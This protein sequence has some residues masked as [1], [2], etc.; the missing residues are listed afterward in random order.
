MSTQIQIV[1]PARLASTRL[2]EKLLRDAEGK[3]IL[4]R[5]FEAASRSTVADGVIVAVDDQRLADEVESFGGKWMMTSR[6]CASGTDRIAEVA[7][8]MKEVDIFVNVQGDE[9]EIEPVV[10]DRVATALIDA[11]DAD[12][13]TVGTPIRDQKILD[14]P[15]CVK[16][17]MAHQP[18]ALAASPE[19]ASPTR[20][21]QGRAEQGR[22]VYFSRAVV[23]H[24]RDGIDQ[25]TLASEPPIY[26]HHIGLYA[27]RRDFLAW[28][29][30]QPP[31]RLE[32]TERLEQ[33]RAIEAGKKIVVSR[34]ESATPGI[35]TE[36]DL[37]AFI[38]RL[39]SER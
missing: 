22:A 2:P 33:L 17:V 28:F 12:M 15:S 25:S 34:V 21:G 24:C 3:S 39:Q 14:D 29:A 36:A 9:P 26:W 16:I 7:D 4:Q 20:A 23:P 37:A 31:S 1:I 32:E 11:T 10:I 19:R 38:R 6:D 35:D 30:R 27:Y 8:E 13:S 18:T 5:T